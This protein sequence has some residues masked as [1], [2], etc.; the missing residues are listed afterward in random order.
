M[1]TLELAIDATKAQQGAQVAQQAFTQ[2][3]KAAE[4]AAR[5]VQVSSQAVSAA[6]Q[7]TG[8]TVQVAGGITATAKALTDLNAAAAS[9]NA[10]RLLLEIG[11][12]A[13]DFKEVAAGVKNVSTTFDVYGNK[14]T[15]VTQAT[16]RFGTVFATLN[17]IIKANPLLA[18]VTAISAIGTALTLFTSETKKATDA[19][20]EFGA[21]L[22]KQRISAQAA[23]YLGIAGPGP[24]G[25]LAAIQGVA[26]RQVLPGA[27]PMNLQQFGQLGYGA[28]AARYLAQQ[29]TPEQQRMALEYMRTGGYQS[30]TYAYGAMGTRTQVGTQ[31]QQGLPQIQLDAAQTQAVL[32]GIYQSIQQ[33]AP[34][35]A[36]AASTGGYVP[37]PQLAEY[38]E[39]MQGPLYGPAPAPFTSTGTR[40]MTGSLTGMGLAD[41]AMQAAQLGQM[42]LDNQRRI[43]ELKAQEA[44]YAE[45]A[46]N[47]AGQVGGTLGAAFA[48][49]LMKTTT[50]RQAFASIVSSFA[51]QGLADIGSAIFRGAVAGL[52]PQQ[53]QGN[54]GMR[55]PGGG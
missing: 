11:K 8:G 46:A 14:V 37:N 21:A 33:Q 24:Q 12:T 39:Q 16:G 2:V 25:S 38:Y 27:A 49:V 53:Q 10:A 35:A 7:A 30:P 55:T 4:G 48:D 26:E 42:A 9:S 52:T 29:G 6:F 40:N 5:S 20:E 1:A 44:R 23:Q 54:A 51:R 17:G 32:R 15:T 28:T 13:Q 36:A 3:Q 19:Y 34:T 22:Q 45:Q 18:A 41:T 43:T 47:Y 31:F 50:L